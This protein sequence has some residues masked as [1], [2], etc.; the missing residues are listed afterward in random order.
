[1]SVRD[2]AKSVANAVVVTTLTTVVLKEGPRVVREVA[3]WGSDVW[4][5]AK[6]YRMEQKIRQER[7]K[8]RLDGVVDADFEDKDPSK[9]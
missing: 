6:T 8:R 5:R 1:M 2:T 9:R 3:N 4:E 7:N